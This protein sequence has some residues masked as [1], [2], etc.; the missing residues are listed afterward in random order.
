MNG[1]GMYTDGLSLVAS[2]ISLLAFRI[3][4]VVLRAGGTYVV[5]AW[6]GAGVES[7]FDR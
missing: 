3:A 7:R 1:A 6:R 4:G 5:L 2:R